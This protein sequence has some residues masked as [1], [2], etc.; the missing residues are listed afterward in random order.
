M[1]VEVYVFVK[2][3]LLKGVVNPSSACQPLIIQAE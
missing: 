2:K 1:F 3:D